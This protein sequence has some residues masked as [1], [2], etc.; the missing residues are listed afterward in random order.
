MFAVSPNRPRGW[1]NFQ[2]KSGNCT[3]YPF[4]LHGVLSNSYVALQSHILK[5]STHELKENDDFSCH[6]SNSLH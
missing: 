1:G 6:M 3:L 5:K 2:K 4:F